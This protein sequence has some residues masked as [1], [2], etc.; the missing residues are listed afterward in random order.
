MP[1]SL[2]SSSLNS[3]RYDSQLLRCTSYSKF[4]EAVLAAMLIKMLCQNALDLICSSLRSYFERCQIHLPTVKHL[5]PIKCC[6][7]NLRPFFP[8][9][10][11]RPTLAH[12][13]TA[14]VFH[15]ELVVNP[16]FS[17]GFVSFCFSQ[18][19]MYSY[20]YT[21][22]IIIRENV[23]WH[24]QYSQVKLFLAHFQL[25]LWSFLFCIYYSPA[26]QFTS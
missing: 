7:S 15:A 18:L 20:G 8:C 4:S 1:L 2:R 13:F 25:N 10:W 9:Y 22:F 6:D 14:S 24:P 17:G 16:C 3:S 5:F 21:P 19:S 23:S 11:K 26:M 12:G